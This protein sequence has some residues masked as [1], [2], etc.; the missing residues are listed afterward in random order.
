ML[1]ILLAASLLSL[2][3]TAIVGA[4]SYGVQSAAVAGARARAVFLAE[5]GLEAVRNIRDAGFAALPNGTFGLVFAG[6]NQ[7]SL[8]PGADVTDGV[9]T[10]QVI[11]SG[12]GA[13][14]KQVISTISW[15]ETASR[16]GTVTLTTGLSNWK[17]F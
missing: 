16:Q 10:R 4:L 15:Q 12:N 1:E 7:W 2:M 5:E 13:N 8:S 11:I 3:V 14:R 9:F 6:L 17:P